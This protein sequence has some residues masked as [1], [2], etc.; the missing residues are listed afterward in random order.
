[1]YIHIHYIL[2]TAMKVQNHPNFL[3]RPTHFLSH[4]FLNLISQSRL[5][6]YFSRFI[7]TYSYSDEHTSRMKIFKKLTRSTLTFFR[8]CLI[9]RRIVLY[10]SRN[11]NCSYIASRIAQIYSP[12]IR[13]S[14]NGEHFIFI[15]HAIH[16]CTYTSIAV[17]S[18]VISRVEYP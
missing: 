7:R 2:D 1:M 3:P 9:I 13:A 6:Q 18:Q 11:R 12:T 15:V 4:R 5:L 14:N 16:M 17:P 8:N 10:S